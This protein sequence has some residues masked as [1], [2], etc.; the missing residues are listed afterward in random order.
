MWQDALSENVILR[1]MVPHQPLQL[2][3]QHQCRGCAGGESGLLGELIDVAR[4]LAQRVKSLRSFS[5]SDSWLC[6]ATGLPAAESEIFEYIGA[7]THQPRAVPQERIGPFR[8]LRE[9]APG[10]DEDFTALV[11]GK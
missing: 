5:S 6:V 7:V 4:L 8:G 9:D 3:S 11:A 1:S 10:N 2:H